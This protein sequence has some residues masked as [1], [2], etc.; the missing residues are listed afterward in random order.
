MLLGGIVG[1]AIAW[2]AKRGIYQ[3]A[4]AA[5]H[6]AATATAGHPVEQGLVQAFSVDICLCVLLRHL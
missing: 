5:P 3:W 4:G 2:G 1:S 6:A